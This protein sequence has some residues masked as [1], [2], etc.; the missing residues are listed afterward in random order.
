MHV[1]MFLFSN[2]YI[3][4]TIQRVSMH[5]C[6]LDRVFFKSMLPT[7]L[8]EWGVINWVSEYLGFKLEVD[9]G[10]LSHSNSSQL[11]MW[12]LKAV[13][14]TGWRSAFK[15][16][17]HPNWKRTEPPRTGAVDLR[18]VNIPL[19]FLVLDLAS[20]KRVCR[21]P[22]PAAMSFFVLCGFPISR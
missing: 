18:R 1:P 10:P 8:G 16:N 12:A 2:I 9:I 14:G 6:I 15:S 4:G 11:V 13:F 22:C 20:A 7:P 17:S 3:D 19:H 21:L 5:S